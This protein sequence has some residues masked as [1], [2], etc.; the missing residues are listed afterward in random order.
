MFAF[1]Y[2]AI[3]K[4]S[5]V[6]KYPASLVI[7]TLCDHHILLVHF[8]NQQFGV[9]SEVRFENTWHVH[10]SNFENEMQ[11]VLNILFSQTCKIIMIEL[12]LISLPYFASAILK[13]SD[14][15]SSL[16]IVYFPEKH[17]NHQPTFRKENGSHY[18]V[19][20]IKLNSIVLVLIDKQLTIDLSTGKFWGR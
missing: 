3:I 10:S 16:H 17:F 1:P 14:R 4:H 12:R 11:T 8:M 18:K 2:P 15:R 6:Q 5:T 7:F 20:L 19:L 9:I 13:K